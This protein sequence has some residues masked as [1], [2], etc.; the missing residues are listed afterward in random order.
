VIAKFRK[1]FSCAHLYRQPL[2]THEQNQKEFGLCFTEYGH[3]HDYILEIEVR[4]QDP[5]IFEQSLRQVIAKI[6]HQHLN[7][8]IPEFQ[9]KVPTTENLNLYL[10]SELEKASTSKNL[11]ILRM[12]LFE[13]PD[14]WVEL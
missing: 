8:V 6:D 10:K 12:K 5:L 1:T 11:Q 9:S 13:T 4:A 7:F 3:G 14:I 2:W